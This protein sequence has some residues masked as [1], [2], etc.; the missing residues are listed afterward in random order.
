MADSLPTVAVEL[1]AL[2][3]AEFTQARNA[4][5]ADARG[6]GDRELA[7]SIRQLKKPSSSAWAV[8]MLVRNRESEVQQLLEL[9]EALRAAQSD[10]D[11]DQLRELGKQR[12]KLIAAV[13]RQARALADE[14]GDPIGAAAADEVGQTLQAALGDPHAADAVTAGMLTRPLAA[15]GWGEVD[16][17]ASSALPSKRRSAT[18]TNISE[19]Q[20]AK[21]KRRVES[22]EKAVEKHEADAL[23]VESKLGAVAAR[24]RDLGKELRELERRVEAVTRELEAAEREQATL[25]RQHEK[26][27]AALEQAAGVLTEA[28]AELKRLS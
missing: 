8:N 15:E 17:D 5:A 21:A 27:E 16:I 24:H 28:E 19:R 18:V 23:A 7:D 20:L 14:L 3:L 9:G 22:A 26:A 12:Q 11:A 10:L 13:V 6:D 2:P 25:Q 4:R 1:Y